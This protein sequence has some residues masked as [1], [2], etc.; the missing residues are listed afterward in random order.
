MRSEEGPLA[1]NWKTV[2]PASAKPWSAIACAVIT[3]W[4]LGA[5]L[6]QPTCLARGGQQAGLAAK[7]FR[8]QA[9]GLR[10]GGCRRGIVDGDR[11]NSRGLP[12]W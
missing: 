6:P 8:H 11:R 4:P 7:G 1:S 10:T 2:T 12:Q 3:D 5:V 9:L